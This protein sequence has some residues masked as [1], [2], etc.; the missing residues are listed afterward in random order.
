MSVD[1]PARAGSCDEYSQVLSPAGGMYG[2]RPSVA[3]AAVDRAPL[4]MGFETTLNDYEN[5]R[6]APGRPP[7]AA[8]ADAA[9][10]RNQP[11]A[12]GG[13]T[14]RPSAIVEVAW[15]LSALTT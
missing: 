9:R 13:R 12:K 6:Y 5:A 10:K 14:F 8:L 3:G 11:A 15:I 7:P 4:K 2:G 1:I